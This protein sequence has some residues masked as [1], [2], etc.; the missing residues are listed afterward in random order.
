MSPVYARRRKGP[1]GG[2]AAADEWGK[3][4]KVAH[5]R[6][7]APEGR[8]R[9]TTAR[10][11]QGGPTRSGPLQV[12]ANTAMG[13]LH[14]DFG[15]GGEH[16]AFRARLHDGVSGKVLGLRIFAGLNAGSGSR[17]VVGRAAELNLRPEQQ[18]VRARLAVGHAYA[19]GVDDADGTNPA[20]ELHMGV[21]ADDGGRI[22]F[23]Q[24]RQNALG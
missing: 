21:A 13:S 19:A 3:S 17:E 15:E 16:L 6:D 12:A 22:D 18:P 1:G 10:A 24:G 20:V 23:Q 5:I 2:K 9:G 7:T 14:R 8:G 11:G 4:G